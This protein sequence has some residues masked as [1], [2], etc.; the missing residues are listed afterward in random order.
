MPVVDVIGALFTNLSNTFRIAAEDISEILSAWETL[1]GEPPNCTTTDHGSPNT[2]PQPGCVAGAAGG[3]VIHPTP[4]CDAHHTSDHLTCIDG[5][6]T[7][8]DDPVS[9]SDP[10]PAD[11]LATSSDSVQDGDKEKQKEIKPN[12]DIKPSTRRVKRRVPL[13]FTSDSDTEDEGCNTSPQH[14]SVETPSHVNP[15]TRKESVF[16]T[17]RE[18]NRKLLAKVPKLSW[19]DSGDSDTKQN[20]SSPSLYS[21]STSPPSSTFCS[22]D[23]SHPSLVLPFPPLPLSRCIQI[24]SPPTLLKKE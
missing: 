13:S 8:C 4:P 23:P 10:S 21:I 24:L 3:D 18:I 11:S 1:N 5:P 6:S 19:P 22:P 17:V 12:S 14:T 15:D 2:D 20:E 9:S 7:L 16:T